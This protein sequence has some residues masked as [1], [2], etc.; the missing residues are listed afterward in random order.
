M[1]GDVEFIM[2]LDLHKQI[3]ADHRYGGRYLDK[4]R[5]TFKGYFMSR[6]CLNIV[7]VLAFRIC[8]AGKFRTLRS[9]KGSLN[10]VNNLC[11]FPLMKP[12]R[13]HGPVSNSGAFF[14]IQ[15]G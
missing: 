14:A 2:P 5:E 7:L 13:Q 1:S 15:A 8:L 10:A 12:F 6:K 3:D 11:A 9:V 4:D